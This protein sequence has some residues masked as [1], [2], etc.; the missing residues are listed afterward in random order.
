MKKSQ[1]NILRKEVARLK[2]ILEKLIK[3]RR[4]E[5]NSQLVLQPIK[6]KNI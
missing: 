3:P 4:E 6:N 5:D 2:K 1:P